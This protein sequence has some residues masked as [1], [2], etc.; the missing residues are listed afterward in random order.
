MDGATWARVGAARRLGRIRD[1]HPP[2]KWLRRLYDSHHAAGRMAA[3]AVGVMW[4]A[5]CVQTL[6]EFRRILGVWSTKKIPDSA[7][8]GSASTHSL[9]GC[10]H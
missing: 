2:A 8:G 6:S 3:A 4:R 1:S 5:S 9:G 7:W 10:A